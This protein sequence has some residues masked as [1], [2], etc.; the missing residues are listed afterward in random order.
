MLG[1]LDYLYL[2]YVLFALG[3][4]VRYAVLTWRAILGVPP[5]AETGAGSTP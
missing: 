4:I 3:V 2:I 5:D 1:R